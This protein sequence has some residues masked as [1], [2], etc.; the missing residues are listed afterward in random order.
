MAFVNYIFKYFFAIIYYNIIYGKMANI[1]EIVKK[2][3]AY[4]KDADI[5]LI[6]KAYNLAS[7]VHK[8]EKRASGEPFITHPLEVANLCADFK[9]DAESICAALLHDTIEDKGIPLQKIENDFG[10][11]IATMVDGLT[12]IT[13]LK[14]KS[15]EEYQFESMRKMLI[16]TTQDI[17]IIVIKLLDK[18]HNMRTLFYLPK[19]KQIR[20]AK[21]VMGIYAPL[22]YR[23][24]IN[25]VKSQ[26][27]DL[28]FK[29][30]DPIVYRSISRKVKGR[31]KEREKEVERLRKELEKII[32]E[33]NI[34]AKVVGRAKSIYSIYKK[35]VNKNRA[36]EEIFDVIA[37][38]VITD[39]VENCYKILGLV[40][41]T[42]KP[43][44][45]R[46]KDYIAMPKVNMY[47]SLHDV[48]IGPE[49]KIIEI[50]IRTKEMDEIA[51]EGIAAHWKYKG[52]GAGKDFDKKLSWLRQIMEWQQE[53]K[54]AKEFV[55]SLE[56]DFFKDEIYTFTPK[57]DVIELPKNSTPLDFAYAVHTEIGNHCVG[58]KVNGSFVSLRHELK[59]GDVV[60]ILVSK[61]QKPSRNWLNIAKTSK[62]LQKIKK[63]LEEHEKIPA[64]AFR[65]KKEEEMESGSTKILFCEGVKNPKFKLAHCCLPNPGDKIIGLAARTGVVT[66]HKKECPFLTKTARKKVRVEWQKNFADV[67]I[68]KIEAIDRVGLFADVL[69]T[70]SA[71]GTNIQSANAKTIGNNMAECS[72]KIKVED[73]EHIKELIDRIKRV[74]GIKKTYLGSVGV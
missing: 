8:D 57:G 36:F 23:L 12:K 69:N 17:R 51:E 26:L 19:E 21:E 67:I 10:K 66:V 11:D 55:E 2:V 64:K 39:T 5:E 48:V 56:I 27:E 72:F 60:E 74:G 29:Y 24:G 46:F 13:Q 58:A 32:Q 41:N 71:T 20:I 52:V 68:L 30:L 6:K 22:A 4:D 31:A 44:P 61:S 49:G 28:A 3:M 1:D 34:T 38:R 33:Q 53:T 9:M 70:I 54:T 37:L 47:Q 62:A 50:Q 7:E 63:F 35:M 18:L 43:I 14:S 59:T 45:Q 15:R 65:V 40:H 16:A 42:W 25:K 73:L